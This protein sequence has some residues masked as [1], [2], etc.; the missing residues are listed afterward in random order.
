[1]HVRLFTSCMLFA[2]SHLHKARDTNRY[3]RFHSVLTFLPLT[4]SPLSISLIISLCLYLRQYSEEWSDRCG[5]PDLQSAIL[6]SQPHVNTPLYHPDVCVR[7]CVQFGDECVSK[8]C[9]HVWFCSY[10]ILLD[11]NQSLMEELV[12]DRDFRNECARL[13]HLMHHYPRLRLTFFSM[14]FSHDQSLVFSV[15]KPQQC[16]DVL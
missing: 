13:L 9:L 6:T 10:S 2:Y 14:W 16:S 8:I 5:S 4:L 12:L 1:M 3:V 7:V 11:A 15:I